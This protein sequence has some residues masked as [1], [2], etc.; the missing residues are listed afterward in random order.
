MLGIADHM[1][2][3]AEL[4]PQPGRGRDLHI[5]PEHAGDCDAVERVESK[6]GDGFSKGFA[7]G[8]D[9]PA[10]GDMAGRVHE[11]HAAFAADDEAEGIEVFLGSDRQDAVAGADHGLLGGEFDGILVAALDA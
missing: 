2:E 6:L 7:A 1:E 11:I 9:H 5:A 8:D 4:E 3:I 10:E